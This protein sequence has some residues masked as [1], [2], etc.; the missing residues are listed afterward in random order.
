MFCVLKMR[1][2]RWAAL[3]FIFCFIIVRQRSGCDRVFIRAPQMAVAVL[4]GGGGAAGAS[5]PVTLSPD[6]P[7]GPHPPN[8]ES[9]SIIK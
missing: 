7:C 8:V 4:G 9:A 1:W 6:P 5:A 2:H 3:I